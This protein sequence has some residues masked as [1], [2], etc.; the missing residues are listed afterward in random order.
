[1]SSDLGTGDDAY[2]RTVR[3]EVA[4]ELITSVRAALYARIYKLDEGDDA[5][6]QE[7]ARLEQKAI[8]LRR[9]IGSLDCTK[10]EPIEAAIAHWGP[11]LKDKQRLWQALRDDTPPLDA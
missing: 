3:T 6:R 4:M 11:L 9:L 8:G 2:A 1:M 10:Q 5:D 7:A